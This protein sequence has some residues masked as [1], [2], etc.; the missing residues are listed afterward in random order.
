MVGS[1]RQYN[2]VRMGK[3][4]SELVAFMDSSIKKEFE[5]FSLLSTLCGGERRIKVDPQFESAFLALSL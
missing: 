3:D 2:G 1:K 4:A 5:S